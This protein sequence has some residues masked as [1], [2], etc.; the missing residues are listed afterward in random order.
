MQGW[1]GYLYGTTTAGGDSNAGVIYKISTTGDL[2]VVVNF[3]SRM[4]LPGYLHGFAQATG[5]EFN[6]TAASFHVISDTYMT[7]TVPAGESGFVTVETSLGTLT[8]N[9]IFWVTPK[10]TT[11]SPP[12]GGVGTTLTINGSGL[13]QTEKITVDGVE[14]QVY[15]VNSDSELTTTVPPGAQTGNIVVTTPAGTAT[16]SQV[17][18]VASPTARP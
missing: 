4:Y 8:S 7:A 10:L 3:D 17:F 2:T 6:G 5:V 15:T 1:D 13:I 12:A 9:K 11:F 16:S 18:T 14:V